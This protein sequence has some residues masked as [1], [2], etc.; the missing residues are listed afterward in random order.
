[1]SEPT[2]P[3]TDSRSTDV[4]VVGSGIAG[5]AA[6]LAAAREGDDVLLVTKASEPEDASS[7]WAQGGIATTRGDP[8]SLKKDIIAASANTADSEAVDVLV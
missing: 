1:M 6:A 5:C 4:L 2:D 3:Q 7:D 8:D